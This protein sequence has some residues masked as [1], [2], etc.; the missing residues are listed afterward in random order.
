[1]KAGI[2]VTGKKLHAAAGESGFALC[3][4]RLQNVSSSDFN[5]MGPLA[6]RR[7]RASVRRLRALG[8]L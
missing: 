7:C 3:N 8:Y 4:A 1:M 5:E 6:C 2:S